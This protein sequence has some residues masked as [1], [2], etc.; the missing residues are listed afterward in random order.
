M[1]HIFVS[2][3]FCGRKVV[4]HLSDTNKISWSFGLKDQNFVVYLVIVNRHKM[5]VCT[6]EHMHTF[7]Y[8]YEKYIGKT[9]FGGIVLLKYL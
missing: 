1:N 9:I 4:S 5:H 6:H 7:T 2:P 3:T 8:I